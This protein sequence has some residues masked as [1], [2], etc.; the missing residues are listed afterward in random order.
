MIDQL[1]ETWRI[2]NRA[3]LLLLDALSTEA[4]HTSIFEK[5]KESPAK[6]FAHIHN[7]R[8]WKL[9]Q[10]DEQLT[11][12]QGKIS[13]SDELSHELLRLKLLKS[14]EIIG[15]VLKEGFENDGVIKGF[16]RGA[17]TLMGYFISHESHH[18]GNIMLSMRQCGYKLPK[19]VTYGL[20]EWNK[21]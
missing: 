8:F 5:E 9:E 21:I 6:Q 7:V 18:R 4:L 11:N 13:P 19:S 15:N 20:W 10:L 2:N 1:V 14:A 16:R 3:N 17:A 12:G